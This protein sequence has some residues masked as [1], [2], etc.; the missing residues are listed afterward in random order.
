MNLLS[1]TATSAAA[2][3]LTLWAPP[4]SSAVTLATLWSRALSSSSALT[5]TTRSGTRQSQPAE[6]SRYLWMGLPWGQEARWGTR[7]NGRA[8]GHRGPVT[9]EIQAHPQRK[10]EV[11]APGHGSAL[12][13]AGGS[14]RT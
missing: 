4:W 7:A 5:P 14:P 3:P 13:W 1:N 11:G 8:R 9:C 10:E 12:L 6:V 2:P